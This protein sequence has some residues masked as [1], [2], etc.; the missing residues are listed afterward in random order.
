MTDIG[1]Y[2]TTHYL[3][4]SLIMLLIFVVAYTIAKTSILRKFYLPVALV[5]GAIILFIGP[6]VLGQW[7]PGW[8]L[9]QEFYDTWSIL[10]GALINVV[11]ACLF[12]GHPV[13]GFKKM[14]HMAGQQV[15]YG[16][17]IAWGQYLIGGLVALLILIPFFSGTPLMGSLLEIAFEGSHGTVAGLQLIWEQFNFMDGKD[18]AN[19]LATLS[20]ISALV[21]GMILINWGK[22]K[23]LVAKER[24]IVKREKGHFYHYTLIRAIQKQAELMHDHHM[25]VGKMVRQVIL[26]AVSVGI[27]LGLRALLILLEENTWGQAG[28][29]IFVYVPAFSI[30][31]FGGIIVNVICQKLNIHISSTANSM[32]ATLSLG[33]LIMTAVGTMNLSFMQNPDL[34][35]SFWILFAAGALWL[36]LSFVFIA[37]RIF[38]KHWFTNAIIS[39]GQGMGMT[40]TGL[41]FAQVVDPEQKTGAVEAFGYKQLLFEPFMGGGLVTAMSIPLIFIIGLPLWTLICGVLTL[42]WL[43]S[44]IFYFS[45][46]SFD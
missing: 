33:I 21:V 12:L 10:P 35:A 42:F 43:L 38:L 26:V 40:A 36:I 7:Q 5:A 24:R 1:E 15:A 39:F 45:K 22:R 30:C 2:L 46:K 25:T 23:G 41:L 14:W 9:P 29:Q 13:L 34:M 18:L 4:A 17:M 16:Q 27:G 32:I 11:F 6:Q 44:G 28:V 20:L 3:T 31:M 19:G 37:R 8:A